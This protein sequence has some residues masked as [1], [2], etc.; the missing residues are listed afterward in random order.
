M[1]LRVPV[2]FGPRS[3]SSYFAN[4][5][6][7][8]WRSSRAWGISV[9]SDSSFS[10]SAN[11]AETAMPSFRLADCAT[12]SPLLA[13]ARRCLNEDLFYSVVY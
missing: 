7:R 13:N 1:H 11:S 2:P 9:R 3:T 5:S 4:S 8:A 10:L 12:I 6:S